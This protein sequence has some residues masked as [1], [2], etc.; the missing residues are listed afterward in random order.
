M[1]NNYNEINNKLLG[2]V[3]SNYYT[4]TRPLYENG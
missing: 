1:N 4:L 2:S 3:E